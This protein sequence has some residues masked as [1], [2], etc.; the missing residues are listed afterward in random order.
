MLADRRSL[1]RRRIR[2]KL[3]PSS[4]HN[5]ADPRMPLADFLDRGR[6]CGHALRAHR[7]AGGG[8]GA[9]LRQG[10]VTRQLARTIDNARHRHAACSWRQGSWRRRARYAPSELL[11]STSLTAT[12]PNRSRSSKMGGPVLADLGNAAISSEERCARLWRRGC[13]RWSVQAVIGEATD[14]LE[15]GSFETPLAERGDGL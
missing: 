10:A 1:R 12:W 8:H 14:R 9:A 11:P 2:R 6:L 13:G 3:R 7:R 15:S 5:R 4:Q